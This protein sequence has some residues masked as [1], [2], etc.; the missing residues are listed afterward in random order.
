[1]RERMCVREMR[2]AREREGDR[3]RGRERERIGLANKIE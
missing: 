1:M 2:E 3:K